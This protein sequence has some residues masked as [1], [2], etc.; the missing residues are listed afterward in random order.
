MENWKER[1]KKIRREKN[2]KEKKNEMR[3]RKEIWES[4]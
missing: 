4:K 3:E 2:G 1:K